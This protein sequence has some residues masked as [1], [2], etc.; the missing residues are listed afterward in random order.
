MSKIIKNSGKLG[1][2][3]F[4]VLL[5]KFIKKQK[6]QEGEIFL[7]L[8]GT[9][10]LPEISSLI[11]EEEKEPGSEMNYTVMTEEEFAYRKKSNDPFIWTFLKQPKLMIL[12]DEGGLTA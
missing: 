7:L 6:G 12:G 3:K 4:A 9:I 1:K 8:V 2:I 5:L 10:V 11:A